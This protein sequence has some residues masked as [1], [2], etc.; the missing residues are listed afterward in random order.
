MSFETDFPSLKGK[1]YWLEEGE[2]S[3]L[4][5]LSYF[6]DGEPSAFNEEFD[7]NKHLF[8]AKDIQQFCLDKQKVLSTINNLWK[9]RTQRSSAQGTLEELKKELGL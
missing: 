8:M 6:S 1:Y 7:I 9:S 3:W 5:T 2:D 4:N